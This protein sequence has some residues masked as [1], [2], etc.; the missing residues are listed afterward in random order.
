MPRPECLH[1]DRIPTTSE[2]PCLREDRFRRVAT[3]WFP[4]AGFMVSEEKIRTTR[5]LNLLVRF[6]L[7]TVAL[8]VEWAVY[9][10]MVLPTLKRAFQAT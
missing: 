3:A 7:A 1:A 2:L 5:R 10:L 9:G 4:H 6:L 8:F